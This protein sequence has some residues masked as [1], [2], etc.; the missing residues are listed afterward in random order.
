MQFPIIPGARR[1]I[2]HDPEGF[3]HRPYDSRPVMPR[4]HKSRPGVLRRDFLSGTISPEIDEAA[5]G[6]T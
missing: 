1:E 6:S 2:R 5:K 4:K 3:D